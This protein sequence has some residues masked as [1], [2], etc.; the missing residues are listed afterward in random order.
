FSPDNRHVASA[1]VD[2]TVKLWDVRTQE[3]VL[4]LRDVGGSL[5]FSPDGK[6]LAASAGDKIRLWDTRTG[7]EAV[8]RGGPAGGTAQSLAFSRDGSRLAAAWSA[9][10]KKNPHEVRVWDGTPGMEAFTVH[11]RCGPVAGLAFSTDGK[12]LAAA[13]LGVGR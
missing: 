3:V 2:Q 5:V 12:Q 13:G 1:G 8:A 4:S 9:P 7:Q 10:G 11:G 6:R